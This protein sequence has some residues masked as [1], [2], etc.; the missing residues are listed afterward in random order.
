MRN[1]GKSGAVN[2][3]G[4]SCQRRRQVKCSPN[5]LPAP[6]PRPGK[7]FYGP[8]MASLSIRI[9]ACFG[10]LLALS[11]C[12]ADRARFPSLAIRPAERAYG[13]GQQ[14]APSGTRPLATQL[15]SSTDLAT[16]VKGL[17]ETAR[18]AHM[19][20]VDQHG[21]AL[22]LVEAAKGAAPGSDAWSRA[23]IALAGLISARSEGMVALA[24]LDGLLIAATE[25]AAVGAGADLAIVAPAQREVE[26]RLE[27]EDRVIAALGEA[28]TA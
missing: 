5:L 21:A 10:A 22:R 11:A 18:A 6:L 3:T 14:A 16:Q 24:E 26:A 12:N 19:R 7:S 17:R 13:S 9:T 20:F 8:L 25:A 1:P 23:T 27:G 28:I 2:R 4:L 15:S